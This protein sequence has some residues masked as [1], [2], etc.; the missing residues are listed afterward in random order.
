MQD[1]ET[2]SVIKQLLWVLSSAFLAS[3]LVCVFLVLSIHNVS[4]IYSEIIKVGSNVEIFV[5][6]EHLFIFLLQEER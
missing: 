2:D 6:H 1:W 5:Y 3:H 4:S